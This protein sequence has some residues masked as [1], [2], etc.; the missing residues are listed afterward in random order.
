MRLNEP[1]CKRWPQVA[2]C[3]SFS[4]YSSIIFFIKPDIHNNPLA[5]VWLLLLEGDKCV[6]NSVFFFF[7]IYLGWD[8]KKKKKSRHA[9]HYMNVLPILY[10]SLMPE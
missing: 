9:P 3:F 7:F 5:S 4:L 10:V 2:S 6:N 1:Y 8:P